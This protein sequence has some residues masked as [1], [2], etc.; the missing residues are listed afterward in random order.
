MNN[1]ERK[2]ILMCKNE[3]NIAGGCPCPLVEACKEYIREAQNNE[4]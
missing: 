2:I 3:G 4:R 1:E